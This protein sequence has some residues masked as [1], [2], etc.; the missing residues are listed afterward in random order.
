MEMLCNTYHCYVKLFSLMKISTCRHEIFFYQEIF[1]SFQF[2][3][4][5]GILLDLD[6][7]IWNR[8]WHQQ[9]CTQIDQ[10]LTF[11]WLHRRILGSILVCVG[12]WRHHLIREHCFHGNGR[13]HYC[14]LRRK[15]LICD[16]VWICGSNNLL[17]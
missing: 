7:Q 4:Q 11:L 3:C 17:S 9:P 1:R 2:A 6:S 16:E 14:Y 13:Q 12:C 8:M 10:I 15:Q 5:N